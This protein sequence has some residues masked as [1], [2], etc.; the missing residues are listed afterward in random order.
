MKH[1]F[2]LL[3]IIIIVF[4]AQH[5]LANY[6]YDSQPAWQSWSQSQDAV[7]NNQSSYNYAS[8][9]DWGYYRLAPA[10]PVPTPVS[11]QS[12]QPTTNVSIINTTE[13]TA[14]Q[15]AAGVDGQFLFSSQTPVS[16][17]S[18]LSAIAAPVSAATPSPTYQYT[19]TTGTASSGYTGST[20]NDASVTTTTNSDGGSTTVIQP[21]GTPNS[22]PIVI[23]LR[24]KTATQNDQTTTNQ[25][26]QAGI[27]PLFSSSLIAGFVAMG[28]LM[29]AV[30]RYKKRILARLMGG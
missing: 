11:T 24:P 26:P 14:S 28:Y 18:T 1:L 13:T 21:N 7:Q 16:Y 6:S 3:F 20:T 23:D 19:Y 10:T 27:D 15:S 22:K 12:P 9:N 17:S 29:S 4:T 25:L 8:N 5:A 30:I 2:F